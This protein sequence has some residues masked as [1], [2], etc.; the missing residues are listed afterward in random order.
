MYCRAKAGAA[1]ARY[2]IPVVR[3]AMQAASRCVPTY[4]ALIG[5]GRAAYSNYS[6]SYPGQ[7]PATANR[8][9]TTTGLAHMGAA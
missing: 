3:M 8:G 1:V 5:S 2:T 6:P 4:L 9:Y 7:I